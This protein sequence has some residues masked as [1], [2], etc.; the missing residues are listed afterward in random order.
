MSKTLET[1]VEDVKKVLEPESTPPNLKREDALLLAERIA[2]TVVESITKR[3]RERTP[4]TIYASEVGKP[5]MRQVWYNHHLPL[6]KEPLRPETILKFLYGNILEEVLLYLAKC[7]GHDVQDEQKRFE[8]ELKNGWKVTG[9]QD[10][11]IDGRVVDVKTTSPYGFKE[12]KSDGEFNDKFGYADQISFYH[13]ANEHP[14]DRKPALFV[15]DKQ[16]G[17]LLVREFEPTKI[18][19][20]ANKLAEVLDDG[21]TVPYR[22]YEDEP[23]GKKGNRKLCTQCSYCDY[24]KVCWPGL[25]TFLYSKGPVFLTKV[26]EEPKVQEIKNEDTSI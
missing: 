6:N 19:A 10:A 24:K 22:E 3:G 14:A 23:E 1:L 26:V 12:M 11:V 2:A 7:A 18:L 13:A 17:N 4:K 20:R 16:N 25:R 5:C 15:M 9:R 21:H 8:I